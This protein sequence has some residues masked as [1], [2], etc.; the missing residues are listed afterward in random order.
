MER[1]GSHPI[2]AAA[3]GVVA[4]GA[5]TRG[6]ATARIFSAFAVRVSLD[7]QPATTHFFQPSNLTSPDVNTLGKV[8]FVREIPSAIS[9]QAS[10]RAPLWGRICAERWTL[11][12]TL[13]N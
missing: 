6:G 12:R 5:V 3:A 2:A 11:W 1:K 7:S 4:C 8:P 9:W 10:T 13:R